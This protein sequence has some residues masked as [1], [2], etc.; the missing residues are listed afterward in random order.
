MKSDF[1]KFLELYR[2][3]GVE[4]K[5]EERNTG[6]TL[7]LDPLDK[8]DKIDGFGSFWTEIVFDENGK[9]IEQGIWE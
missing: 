6:K 1:D 7:I 2:S 9:F 8:N 3:V 4:P 5:I